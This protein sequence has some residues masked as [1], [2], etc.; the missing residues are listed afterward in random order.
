M[1]RR[2]VLNVVEKLVSP[3]AGS[4][5][6]VSVTHRPFLGSVAAALVDLGVEHAL[7]YAAIEG[8]DEAPLDGSSTLVRVRNAKTEVFGVTPE[9][10]GLPRATRAQIPWS[11]PEDEARRVLGALEGEEGPACAL[12]LYD[13]ALRLRVGGEAVSPREG[14]N[15][16][17]EVKC[18]G[19][20]L[21]HVQRLRRLVPAG[22]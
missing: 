18:F 11:V 9:S 5:V 2:T 7:V 4:R 8:S 17:R 20:A 12:I 1:A 22:P 3:V 14:V 21:D 16:A 13:A 10:I 19:A 6:V 15:L